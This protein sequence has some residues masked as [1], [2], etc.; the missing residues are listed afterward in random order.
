MLG[1]C[2]KG[3]GTDTIHVPI[4]IDE[5]DPFLRAIASGWTIKE[6]IGARKCLVK[7][8]DEVVLHSGLELH[9]IPEL[10]VH[11]LELVS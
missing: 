5:I 2:R 9:V 7:K 8:A 11:G 10:S 3:H 1:K 6:G 4:G